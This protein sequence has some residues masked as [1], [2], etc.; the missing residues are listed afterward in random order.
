MASGASRSRARARLHFERARTCKSAHK[1]HQHLLR[2]FE[3]ELNLRSPIFSFG[4]GGCTKDVAVTWYNFLLEH[5]K[6]LTDTAITLAEAKVIDP[7]EFD[8][9]IIKE[10]LFFINEE[11]ER[12]K[13]EEGAVSPLDSSHRFFDFFECF[14]LLIYIVNDTTLERFKQGIKTLIE[15]KT[16]G[17]IS[18]IRSSIQNNPVSD[19]ARNMRKK[20]DDVYYTYDKDKDIKGKYITKSEKNKLSENEQLQLEKQKLRTDDGRMIKSFQKNEQLQLNKLR[21]LQQLL[22]APLQSFNNFKEAELHAPVKPFKEAELHAPLKPFKDAEKV[23]FTRNKEIE[24]LIRIPYKRPDEPKNKKEGE[25]LLLPGTTSWEICDDNKATNPKKPT[26]LY[27]N[28]C[29]PTHDEY[30]THEEK[31]VMLRR[32]VDYVSNNIYV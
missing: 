13:E 15:A 27:P 17:A 24:N 30:E 22:Q 8:D 5:L 10:T 20:Y 16:E 18:V 19:T 11:L 25:G 4:D 23:I 28:Y 31:C 26:F 2:T 7:T 12:R 29:K 3:I 32:L 1:R 6:Y 9:L 21:T 14:R